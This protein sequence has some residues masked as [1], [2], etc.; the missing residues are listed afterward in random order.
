MNT[1]LTRFLGY[2]GLTDLERRHQQWRYEQ[3]S[4]E[5]EEAETECAQLAAYIGTLKK[6]REELKQ[7]IYRAE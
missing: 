2:I 5:I 1:V 6:E 4:L 3:I 7:E